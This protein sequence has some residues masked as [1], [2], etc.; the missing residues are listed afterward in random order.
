[1]NCSETFTSSF[2]S[3]GGNILFHDPSVSPCSYVAGQR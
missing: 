3:L 1:M 2:M